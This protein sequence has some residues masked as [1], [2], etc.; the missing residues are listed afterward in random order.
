MVLL[1]KLLPF[2]LTA[3]LG[4]VCSR[5]AF[6]PDG[7]MALANR[8]VFYIGLPAMLFVGMAAQPAGTP[9]ILPAVAVCIALPSG[10][11]LAISVSRFLFGKGASPIRATWIQCSIHAN[12]GLGLPVI[13]CLFGERGLLA[14]G[15]MFAMFI[16]CQN[17]LTTLVY[18]YF[19]KKKNS[20]LRAAIAGICRNPAVAATV[21][22]LLWHELRLPLPAFMLETLR[23]LAGLFLPLALFTVGVHLAHR[24]QEQGNDDRPWTTFLLLA[25]KAFVLPF[26]GFLL[27]PAL[28]LGKLE[29]QILLLCLASPTALV[30]GIFAAELGGSPRQAAAIIGLTHILCPLTYAFWMHL[31]S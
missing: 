2:F 30:S 7:F 1:G 16:V 18:Q 27:A 28:G 22:G 5:T 13:L 6:F 17:L 23:I 20:S 19:G 21:T 31:V 24:K 10:C 12:Q 3:S 9:A 25:H 11:L 8:L 15:P 14:A 29:E 4:F 26:I